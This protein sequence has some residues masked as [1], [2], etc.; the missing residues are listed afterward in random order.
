MNYDKALELAKEDL[1][2]KCTECTRANNILF[3]CRRKCDRIYKRYVSYAFANMPRELWDL[4]IGDFSVAATR[5][6]DKEM[7]I[8]ALKTVRFYMDNLLNAYRKG[9]GMVLY[10]FHGTGKSMLAACVLKEAIRLD[11][12]VKMIEFNDLTSIIRRSK[13]DPDQMEELEKQIETLDMI[14][15][16]NFGVNQFLRNPDEI[17]RDKDASKEKELA[18]FVR[19][20]DYMT[21]EI[22]R[23]LNNRRRAM[24]PNI[25]TTYYNIEELMKSQDDEGRQLMSTITGHCEQIYIAGED[26]RKSVLSKNWDKRVAKR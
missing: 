1:I 23:L 14:C 26:Y 20:P 10:G 4:E 24:L 11:K 19:G 25:I 9:L 16:E 18:R 3:E 8:T 7:R 21:R 15:I 17:S 2:Y 5:P 6:E 13:Q 12:K 22:A